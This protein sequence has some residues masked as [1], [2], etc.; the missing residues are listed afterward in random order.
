MKGRPG[1]KIKLQHIQDA[2]QEIEG[3]LIS[4]DFQEF[5]N[6]SMMRFASIKQME[7]IG[8]ASNHLSEE[9]KLKF[10]EIEWQQIVGLRNVFVHQYFGVDINL[11]WEIIK[12]D[13]PVLKEKIANILTSID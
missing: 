9:I 13:I 12:T 5:I 8:E 10:S 6:N 1:D 4:A 11:V 3:Y 2:I 7:I